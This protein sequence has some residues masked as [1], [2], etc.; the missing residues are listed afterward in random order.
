[1]RVLLTGVSCVGKTAIGM[2][3]KRKRPKQSQAGCLVCKPNKLG[4][5]TEKKLG[6]RGFGKLR[7][8]A[9]ALEDLSSATQLR[10]TRARSSACPSW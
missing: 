2:N 7:K 6:R 10:G 4:K 8:E 1:M 9:A 3:H 5:G